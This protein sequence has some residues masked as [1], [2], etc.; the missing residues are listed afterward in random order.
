LELTNLPE[1]V[2][3]ADITAVVRGGIVLDVFL[4][5]NDGAARVSF[6]HA[7]D[8]EAYYKYVCKHDIYIRDRRVMAP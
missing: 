1:G 4:R 7:E 8:A 3:H 6:V 5:R 2:T